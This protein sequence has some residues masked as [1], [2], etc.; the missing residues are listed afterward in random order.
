M[1]IRGIDAQIM[2]TRTAELQKDTSNVQRKNDLMRDYM[3]AQTKAEELQNSDAVVRTQE[4]AEPNVTLDKDGKNDGSASER[5]RR[6]PQ[7]EY[8]DPNQYL[9]DQLRTDDMYTIDIKV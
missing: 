7:R 2:V 6:E 3:A 5:E 8:E 4:T 9:L 1:S